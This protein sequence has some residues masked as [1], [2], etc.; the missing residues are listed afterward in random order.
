[1][2]KPNFLKR[3]LM[4]RCEDATGPHEATAEHAAVFRRSDSLKSGGMLFVTLFEGCFCIRA[5]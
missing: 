1:M 2:R 5:K 4:R 3:A